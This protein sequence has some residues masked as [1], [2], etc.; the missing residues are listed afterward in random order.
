MITLFYSIIILKHKDCF[1]D[2]SQ[3]NKFGI[4]VLRPEPKN[5]RNLFNEEMTFSKV[6]TVYRSI[7]NH[8]F[9]IVANGYDFANNEL[10]GIFEL[11]ANHS[12]MVSAIVKLGQNI[13]R[14]RLHT[15]SALH[16]FLINVMPP[17]FPG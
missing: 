7:F 17:I 11:E 15:N 8:N 6:V 5:A 10:I 2:L 3:L 4:V 9:R 12:A 16:C 13:F 1:F 14:Q